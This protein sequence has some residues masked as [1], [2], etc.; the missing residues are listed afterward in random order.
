MH[1]TLKYT[2]SQ[3]HTHIYTHIHSYNMLTHAYT[4][5][6]S[7]VHIPTLIYPSTHTHTNTHTHTCTY[8]CTYTL[9]QYTHTHFQA[10]RPFSTVILYLWVGR[11]HFSVSVTNSLPSPPTL[12]N[13]C[14]CLAGS[15]FI[16]LLPLDPLSEVITILLLKH[17]CQVVRIHY[18]DT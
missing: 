8:T 16:S 13:V 5:I 1:K 3:I 10:D 9:T 12:L 2:H 18:S 6:H 11:P 17:G 14:S 15:H 7:H 4:Y